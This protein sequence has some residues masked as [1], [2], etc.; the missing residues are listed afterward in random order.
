[1]SEKEFKKFKDILKKQHEEVKGSKAAAKKLL[2]ELGIITP[3]G[4]Y[5]KVFK[6]TK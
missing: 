4:N 6:Q 2:V 3:K 5:T 1:M